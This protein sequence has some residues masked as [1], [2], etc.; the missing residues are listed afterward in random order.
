MVAMNWLRCM[1]VPSQVYVYLPCVMCA[2]WSVNYKGC[3]A[4]CLLRTRPL[5]VASIMRSPLV[6]SQHLTKW[7]LS[8]LFSQESRPQHVQRTNMTRLSQQWRHSCSPMQFLNWRKHF[9]H[10]SQALSDSAP[11][12][13][14]SGNLCARGCKLNCSLHDLMKSRSTFCSCV[15]VAFMQLGMRNLPTWCY[16]YT[17][18]SFRKKIRWCLY[19]VHVAMLPHHRSVL[20]I[21]SCSVWWTIS[22]S[23]RSHR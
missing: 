2:S 13:N 20:I 12:L 19:W 15:S 8:N 5:E 10:A 16:I 14:L 4:I 18:V 22:S 17:S 3:D 1:G 9:L 23:T 21:C 7:R 11:V 6:L